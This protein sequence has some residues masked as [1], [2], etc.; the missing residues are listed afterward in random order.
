MI[1]RRRDNSSSNSNSSTYNNSYNSNT[2]VPV[3]VAAASSTS[4]YTSTPKK[5][6]DMGAALAD[7]PTTTTTTTSTPTTNNTSTPSTGDVTDTSKTTTTHAPI[8]QQQ[9]QQPSEDA[10]DTE[11]DNDDSTTNNT[12]INLDV[13]NDLDKEHAEPTAHDPLSSEPTVYPNQRPPFSSRLAL[14]W[15]RFRAIFTIHVIRTILWILLACACG[16]GIAYSRGR[17]RGLEFITAYIVEYSLSVDNLFVFLL[18]F[19]YFKVPREAQE[20]VLFWGII[21]AMTFRGI[22]IVVGKALVERFEWVTVCFAALLLYSA[23]KLLLEDDDD[24]DDL[25]NNRIVRFS[26]RLFPVTDKYTGENFFVVEGN[27]LVAT[28]LFVVLMSV[29]LSDVV[30]ALDSVPAVLGISNDSLVIYSSN[31]LAVMGL[32]SLF[33]VVSDAIKNLRFLK[34]SLSIVLGFIGAKMI[35]ASLGYHLNIAISLAV[36]TSTLALGVILSLCFPGPPEPAEKE[37]VDPSSASEEESPVA[38]QP[39]AV[40]P[41]V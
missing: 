1:N 17:D 18:I 36:V 29:E 7:A 16:V 10:K 8:Q 37:I 5:I 12:N 41:P 14:H 31:I 11:S 40:P 22:M 24:D 32:R 26:K 34:Q 4:V 21:G 35:A 20:T 25:E 39:A 9:Q 3:V 23:I 27:R 15:A 28:P 38:T 2:K 6:Y 13:D 30:F 33:F 19:Q